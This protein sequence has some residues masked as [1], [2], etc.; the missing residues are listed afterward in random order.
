MRLIDADKLRA[1]FDLIADKYSIG[2]KIYFN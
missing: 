1:E 2:E